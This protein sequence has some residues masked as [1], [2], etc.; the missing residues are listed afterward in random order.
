MANRLPIRRVSQKTG[1]NNGD[2]LP[3]TI[4]E[5]H[6][7]DMLEDHRCCSNSSTLLKLASLRIRCSLNRE[8]AFS[9]AYR[10]Y[11]IARSEIRGRVVLRCAV[12]REPCFRNFRQLCS[13]QLFAKF[14]TSALKSS[15]LKAY[16]AGA[17]MK[18]E[19]AARLDL[20]CNPA[21]DADFR[22]QRAAWRPRPM[23]WLLN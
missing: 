8:P 9:G 13:W 6:G 1:C 16:D 20:K 19:K 11:C 3:V 18:P 22:V 21:R 5:S 7:R 2:S 10:L 12:L 23:V 15:L 4:L 17:R 14:F